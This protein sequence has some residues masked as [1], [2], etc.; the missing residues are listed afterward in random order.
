MTTSPAPAP[1]LDA[2]NLSAAEYQ[3]AKASMV[4]DS[5][6]KRRDRATA[7]TMETTMKKHGAS[8]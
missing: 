4:A 3:K 7:R 6:R 8:T 1:A 5:F 2:R